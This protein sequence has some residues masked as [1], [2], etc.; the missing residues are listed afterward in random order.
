M[1][2]YSSLHSFEGSTQ[3]LPR[4]EEETCL[5]LAAQRLG[6]YKAETEARNSMSDAENLLRSSKNTR[7][8]VKHLLSLNKKR[9]GGAVTAWIYMHNWLR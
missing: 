3:H 7:A 6:E 1:P 8:V 4:D 2:F 9:T 5:Q